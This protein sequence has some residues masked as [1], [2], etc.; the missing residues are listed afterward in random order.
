[1]CQLNQGA[2]PPISEYTKGKKVQLLHRKQVVAMGTLEFVGASGGEIRKWGKKT[3][4]RD[5]CIVHV[6][7]VTML[8][9]KPPFRFYK[10]PEVLGA[11]V[12]EE[13]NMPNWEKNQ[14]LKELCE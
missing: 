1:M 10:A 9:A 5:K 14:T 4:G 7:K 6:E 8:G 2:D 13:G 11:A 12:D 3:V